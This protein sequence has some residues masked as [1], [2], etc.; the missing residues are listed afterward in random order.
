MSVLGSMMA[1][2][3]LFVIGSPLSAPTPF[4]HLFTG[5]QQGAGGVITDWR[6]NELR[7]QPSP[8]AAQSGSNE[9]LRADW[10]GEVLAA[11]DERAH[12]Q[13]LAKLAF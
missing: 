10:P 2:G 5:I 12:K 1:N 13:A 4:P 7:W 11:G 3:M 9:A 8:E 6:G